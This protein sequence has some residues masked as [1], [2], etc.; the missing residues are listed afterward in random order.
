MTLEGL[1]ILPVGDRI[2]LRVR[3]KVYASLWWS[4]DGQMSEVGQPIQV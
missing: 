1:I 2:P 3:G 4:A